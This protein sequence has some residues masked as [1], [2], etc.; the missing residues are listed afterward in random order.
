[1]AANNDSN[2]WV[3]HALY[4]AKIVKVSDAE[5]LYKK[6]WCDSPD[7]KIL[8]KGIRGKWYRVIIF[9]RKLRCQPGRPRI[10][11]WVGLIVAVLGVTVAFLS[12]YSS[13]EAKDIS[14]ALQVKQNLY[15]AFDLLGMGSNEPDSISWE[16]SRGDSLVSDDRKEKLERVRRL[17]EKIKL[18]EPENKM[19]PVLRL[20]YYLQ[21]NDFESAKAVLQLD[22][23]QVDEADVY[24]L[25]A[26]IWA[27]LRNSEEMAAK[28]FKKGLEISPHNAKLHAAYGLSLHSFEKNV[29]AI[30]QIEEAIMIEPKNTL[31][32]NQLAHV[33]RESGK[34]VEAETILRDVISR[35]LA[36][37]STYNSL[38]TILARKN[39]HAKAI[40][41]F[42]KSIEI[43]PINWKTHYNI[44]VSYEATHDLNQAKK[45]RELYKQYWVLSKEI[46]DRDEAFD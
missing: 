13:Q 42:K 34:I 24:F 29:Q 35:K 36:N 25:M 27:N 5:K 17:I 8:F 45:H 32:L 46:S 3:Y 12:Y 39:E 40:E 7:E 41:F 1:M 14:T 26:T 44:G 38:G 10:F 11:Q 19:I 37:A 28:Y 6:G 21:F 22:G 33:F 16:F 2:T 9:F 43:D 23:K 15:E 31:Y 18:L 30:K 20:I 4:N